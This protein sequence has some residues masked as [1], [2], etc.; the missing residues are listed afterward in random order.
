MF[1]IIS[2]ITKKYKKIR[3]T[4]KGSKNDNKMKNNFHFIGIFRPF[5]CPPK[6]LVFVC[7]SRIY[8]KHFGILLLIIEQ[9]FKF[10]QLFSK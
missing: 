1:G 9:K 5:S 4:A 8:S 3:E 7:D 6:I 2:T 10:S